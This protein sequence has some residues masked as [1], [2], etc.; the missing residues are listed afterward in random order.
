MLETV[1]Y[2]ADCRTRHL[3]FTKALFGLVAYDLI[4]RHSSG[5]SVGSSAACGAL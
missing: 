2:E 1:V 5:I 3:L 4:V